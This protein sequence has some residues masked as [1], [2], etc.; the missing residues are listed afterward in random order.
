M[1]QKI[2][3]LERSEIQFAF[4]QE[5]RR[6]VGNLVFEALPEYY[7]KVPLQREVLLSLLSDQVD[8]PLTELAETYVFWDLKKI[9]G[10]L[11][12]I[13]SKDLKLAQ[14]SGTIILAREMS[15]DQAITFKRALKDYGS[16]I[17]DLKAIE[18]KYL[19][20]LAVAPDARGRGV[21]RALMEHVLSLYPDEMFALHIA[22]TNDVVTKLHR[23][24]GFKRQSNVEL[25]FQAWL[26]APAGSSVTS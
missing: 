15:A 20:R 5:M 25:P 21:A 22:Q 9:L 1:T 16:S 11:S 17:E 8:I 19:P 7:E 18:G 14:M 4:E 13:N 3:K 23:S 6:H 10:L 2:R 12:V 24:L 26:R